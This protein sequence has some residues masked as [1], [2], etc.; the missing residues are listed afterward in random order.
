LRHV[1]RLASRVALLLIASQLAAL[2]SPC[3]PAAAWK[4]VAAAR[5]ATPPC[6]GHSAQTE[7]AAEPCHPSLV[8][9]CPCGCGDLPPPATG[10]H[11]SRAAVLPASLEHRALPAAPPAAR[12]PARLAPQREP[13]GIQHVPRTA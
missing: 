7:R 6:P 1:D 11:F 12:E 2:V 13:S 9:R 8:F 4:E 5:P 10:P 3:P